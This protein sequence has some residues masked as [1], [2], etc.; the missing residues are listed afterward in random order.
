MTDTPETRALVELAALRTDWK[1]LTD[2]L[3]DYI[4]Q[5][6]ICK[7]DMES[8]LRVLEGKQSYGSGVVAGIAIVASI[9]GGVI[10]TIFAWLLGRI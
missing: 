9:L 5:D 7:L 2:K 8:R 4:D 10:A 3:T 6:R 1:N